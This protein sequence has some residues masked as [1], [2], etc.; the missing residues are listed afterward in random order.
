M[1]RARPGEYIGF[2]ASSTLKADLEGAAAESGRSLSAEVQ[3][4]LEQSL[5]EDRVIERLDRLCAGPPVTDRPTDPA[6]LSVRATNVLR[7]EG[8][9]GPLTPVRI[10][11]LSER[12]LL[13]AP[14]CGRTTIKEIKDALTRAGL[15][16]QP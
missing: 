2:R 13:K 8:L 4:R 3:F 11:Q 14:N 1:T 5:R 9:H 7:N 12:E 15:S 16:L 6:S 10:A